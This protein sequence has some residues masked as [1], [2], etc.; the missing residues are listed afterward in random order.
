MEIILDGR[1]VD[2]R[3]TLH[4]RL[5]ELLHLPVWYGRNLDALHDCLTELREP[6]TL[7]VCL[8]YTSRRPLCNAAGEKIKNRNRVRRVKGRALRHVADAKTG[9]LAIRG[10]EGELALIFPLPE[11]RADERR[12]SRAVGPNQRNNLPTVLSLIHI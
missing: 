6:V 9:L 2:S 12:F 3:E 10:M 8:L 11:N 1:T 4:Q 7:R 5:S